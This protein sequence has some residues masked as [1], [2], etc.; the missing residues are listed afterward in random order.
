MADDETCF[1]YM[2]HHRHVALLALVGDVR[3]TFCRHDLRRI[4]VERVA[5]AFT[6]AQQA[7]KDA[8]VHALQTRQPIAFL[9]AHAAQPIAGCVTTWHVFELKKRAQP[10]VATQHPQILQR[11]PAAS[12]HQN[13]RQDMSR[14]AVSR[15]A[16]GTGQLMVNQ[17]ANAHR[18]QIFSIKRQSAM[19]RQ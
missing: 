12:Q 17:L 16:A 7:A 5:G 6:V 9:R 13:Q 11:P 1:R 19:R 4:D 2:P 10:Y 3:L 14:R 15:S 8:A 18:A